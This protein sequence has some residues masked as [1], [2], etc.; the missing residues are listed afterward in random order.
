VSSNMD[1]VH[2]LYR[3]DTRRRLTPHEMLEVSGEAAETVR[4]C[5]P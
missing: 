4:S 1:C 2:L 5:S 3:P